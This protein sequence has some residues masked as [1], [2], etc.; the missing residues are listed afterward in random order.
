MVIIAFCTK[1]FTF[2][3]KFLLQ[4]LLS[5]WCCFSR[6]IGPINVENAPGSSRLLRRGINT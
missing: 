2:K 4:L 3:T 5:F 1:N 6:I